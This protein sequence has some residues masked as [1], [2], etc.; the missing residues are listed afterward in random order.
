MRRLL[1]VPAAALAVFLAGRL[2]LPASALRLFYRIDVIVVAAL[3]VAGCVGAA[4]AFDRGDHLRLAWYLNGASYLF[5]LLGASIRIPLPTR[6]ILV[7]RSGLALAANGL[8]IASM[9]LFARTYRVAGLELPGSPVRKGLIVTS[10]GL[11]AILAAGHSVYLSVRHAAA[12]DLE[13]L[14]GAVSGVGDIVTFTLIAPVFMTALALRGGLLVWPW[15]L[16]VAAN[17]CWLLFDAQDTLTYFVPTVVGQVLE[18][19]TETWRILAC[20]LT[21]CA[22]LAQRRLSSGE[23][24]AR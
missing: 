9:W 18:D 14:M 4:R 3:A 21:F 15:S 13:S 22:G 20:A 24:T 1:L 23:E 6:E 11:L 16:L 7:V 10:A 12:G 17:A 2:L 19:Y 8:A 5:V